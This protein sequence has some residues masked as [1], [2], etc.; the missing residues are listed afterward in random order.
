MRKLNSVLQD[1]LTE[2]F[3]TGS[4]NV[5]IHHI[6][7]GTGRRRICEEYG[8]VVALEPRYHN[9]SNYSVHAVPNEGLD[10]QLKMMAQEYFESHYGERKDF[11]HL[12]GRSYL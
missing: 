10:L 12:F 1:D 6:F 4:K 8:F 3:V 7:P 9:M 2:C 5:A 11:I